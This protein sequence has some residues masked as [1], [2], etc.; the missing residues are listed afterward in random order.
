M[1]DKDKEKQPPPP[2]EEE[3]EK[4]EPTWRKKSSVKPIKIR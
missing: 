2:P 3:K 4:I 1:A